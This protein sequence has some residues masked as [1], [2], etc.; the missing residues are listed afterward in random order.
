MAESAE[1][2]RRADP[3]ET[4]AALVAQLEAEAQAWA[5]DAMPYPDGLLAAYRHALASYRAGDRPEGDAALELARSVHLPWIDKVLQITRAMTATGERM[6]MAELVAG[7]GPEPDAGTLL[8]AG[9]RLHRAERRAPEVAEGELA[10]R[11]RALGDRV[12]VAG[13]PALARDAL[14]A[15]ARA[16]VAQL[17]A[18]APSLAD[19]EPLGRALRMT[20]DV[21]DAISSGTVPERLGRP[22]YP[23]AG[24]VSPWAELWTLAPLVDA[25]RVA[26]DRA[27][28]SPPAL[29]AITAATISARTVALAAM[30]DTVAMETTLARLPLWAE[31]RQAVAQLTLW[32]AGSL[33]GYPVR[34]VQGAGPMDDRAYRLLAH[35]IDRYAEAACPPERRV[36]FTLSEAARWAGYGK[37]G[38]QLRL[39]RDSLLRMRATALES[40]VRYPDGHTE[41]LAWGLIDRGWTTDAVRASGGFV[42]LS[43]ELADLIRR[44]SLVYL[45]APTLDALGERDGMAVIL[46]GFLEGESR[47]VWRHSLFSARQGDPPVDSRGT[48]AIADLLRVSGWDRRRRAKD[49]IVKAC[50]AIMA[51]DPRYRLVIDRGRERGMWTLTVDREPGTPRG[52]RRVL[53]GAL[54]GIP[55]GAS[56]YSW[57]R[58]R[59]QKGG[60]PSSLTVGSSEDSPP[61]ENRANARNH[62]RN[63]DA[64]LEAERQGRP[65]VA[66]LLERTGWPKLTTKAAKFL[67]DLADRHDLTGYA[68]AA[69]RIREAPITTARP[70]DD[71]I[72]YLLEADA[73][74]RGPRL[75]AAEAEDRATRARHQAA[76][77]RPRT[78]P[79]HVGDV[80]P[81]VA[82]LP[83]IRPPVAPPD[84]AIRERRVAEWRRV[85]VSR[86]VPAAA[87]RRAIA[88][89]APDL[90][91]LAELL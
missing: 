29:V 49:R 34:I 19:A 87:A 20:R 6:R 65:D 32:A 68:W 81:A 85:I 56:G 61:S 70:G 40:A 51:V 21:V 5:D 83:S 72:R 25:L 11:R 17:E 48:L 8:E 7:T 30:P 33:Y 13:S 4:L 71:V 14:A 79:A 77:A 15:E 58:D 12:A 91:D 44:G 39:V 60:V 64:M 80:L 88:E 37:G 89:Y 35:L 62:A 24:S 42:T 27:G 18:V 22:A 10:E 75:E 86:E 50:A 78:P 46:W 90:D 26:A 36:P 28:V 84:P 47:P 23:K 52:A 41:S 73:A 2:D 63:R 54:A 45:D 76:Q 67:G 43:D 57:G 31:S 74:W 3:L 82:A 66:A 53:S 9:R 16:L 55:G 38:R 69:E 1:A 59:A